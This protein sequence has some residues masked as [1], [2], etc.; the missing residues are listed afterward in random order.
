M[1]GHVSVVDNRKEGADGDQ[2]GCRPSTSERSL[3]QCTVDGGHYHLS[4]CAVDV[5]HYRLS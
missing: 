3:L 2:E 5:G 4:S 1:L